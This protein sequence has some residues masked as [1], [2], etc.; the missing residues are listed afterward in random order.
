M[1]NVLHEGRKIDSGKTI[2]EARFIMSAHHADFIKNNGEF[3]PY[4]F[5]VAPAA[6]GDDVE[7]VTNVGESGAEYPL[8]HPDIGVPTA[9]FLIGQICNKN[10]QLEQ[11]RG[12]YRIRHDEACEAEE[13]C[14]QMSSI[15]ASILN[16]NNGAIGSIPAWLEGNIRV[17]V[18]E[19][20]E[21]N[22]EMG[23]AAHG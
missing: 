18:S 6:G 7:F 1:Y 8:S 15:L 20:R 9:N 14:R 19:Q 4:Y 2:D 10:I 11:L 5:S 17:A 21:I 13:R 23:E 16:P 22:A 12:E 3:M